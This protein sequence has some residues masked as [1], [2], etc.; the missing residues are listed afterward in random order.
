[1]A[2]SRV[3]TEKNVIE[4]KFERELLQDRR[5]DLLTSRL[6]LVNSRRLI[7]VV[8]GGSF[9]EWSIMIT[10]STTG[11]CPREFK[12]HSRLQPFYLL[13]LRIMP[14]SLSFLAKVETILF[15]HTSWAQF[16]EETHLFSR[17]YLY[18]FTSESE[19]GEEKLYCS[20]DLQRNQNLGSFKSAEPST[21]SLLTFWPFRRCEIPSRTWLRCNARSSYHHVA[22][23]S[24][25]TDYIFWS[26]I[27]EI[28]D[29]SSA[30]VEHWW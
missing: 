27:Y 28:V 26:H 18:Y 7:Q 12:S 1:M 3:S 5:T 10:K 24:G 13:G 11:L 17:R 21:T 9:E 14:N 2:L 6:L 8:Y 23:L 16:R 25:T 19:Y 20:F 29:L 30:R 4:S 15:E 22:M